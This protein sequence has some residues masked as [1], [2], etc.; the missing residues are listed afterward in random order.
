MRLKP[1]PFALLLLLA[2]GAASPAHAARTVFR[3]SDL[4]WRDPHV[5]VSLLGCRDIT[6]TPFGG[7]SVNP[8]LQASIQSDADSNGVLD[9]SHLIVFDPLDQAGAGGTLIFS[10]GTCSAPYPPGLCTEWGNSVTTTY[11]NLPGA[12]LDVL[13]GTTWGPYT[14]EVVTPGA[15]CFVANLGTALF[16]ILDRVPV[17]LTDTWLA[18]TYVGTPAGDLVNGLIRGFLSETSANNTIIPADMPVIGGKSLS[19]VLPGGNPPGVDI[20]CAAHSDMDVGP[21]GVPGWYVYMNFT[22]EPVNIPTAVPSALPGSFQLNAPHPNP[23]NPSTTLRYALPAASH[24]SLVIYDAGGRAVVRLVDG[25][26]PAGEHVATWNGRDGRGRGVSSGVY[27][28]RLI[29]RDG[30]RTQKLVL[31]K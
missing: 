20:C 31:L 24:V 4:D 16:V 7:L 18:A 27:F 8:M 11:S 13:A 15:P 3:I 12:C 9:L 25:T 19:F 21:G 17:V 26:R 5:F 1:V 10:D 14:P 29:A 22:A 6:D 28:A 30:V 23:F 2:L